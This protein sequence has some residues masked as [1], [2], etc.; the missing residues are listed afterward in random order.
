MCR[1]RDYVC[2]ME[3]EV[4]PIMQ[5]PIRR[6]VDEKRPLSEEVVTVKSSTDFVKENCHAAP[7]LDRKEEDYFPVRKVVGRRHP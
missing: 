3:H 4:E 5:Q 6:V 2:H 1:G 7:A